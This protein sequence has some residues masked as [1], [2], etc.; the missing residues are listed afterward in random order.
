MTHIP[1]AFKWASRD[2]FGAPR[3]ILAAVRDALYELRVEHK[4]DKQAW[5]VRCFCSIGLFTQLVF[6]CGWANDAIEAA[7][8][9]V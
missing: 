9:S 3:H 2:A 6:H 8:V 1:D 7:T 5:A 4:V